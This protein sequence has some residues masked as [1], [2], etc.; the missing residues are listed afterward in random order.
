MTMMSDLQTIRKKVDKKLGIYSALKMQH[1]EEKLILRNSQHHLENV[2]EAQIITQSVAQA[3]QQ[4]VHHRISGV[5]CKCL[6]AV[7]QDDYGF[8]IDFVQKR[9]RTEAI[10]MLTKGENEIIDPL[11]ADSGGVLDVAAF[12]L[13]LSCLVLAKPRLRRVLVLDEP[14]KNI[15]E[16]YRDNMRVLLEKLSEDFGVQIIMVT[17]IEEFVTGKIIRL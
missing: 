13:R 6:T 1:R 4:K 2:K 3:I 9:G 15:S 8:R 16:E 11:N 12:A 17:H 10:L 14:F 7:F 5:V